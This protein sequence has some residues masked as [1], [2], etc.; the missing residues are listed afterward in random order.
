MHKRL[1]LKYRL[2]IIVIVSVTAISVLFPYFCTIFNFKKSA[3]R[4][5]RPQSYGKYVVIS[6]NGENTKIDIEEFIP[7]VL[8]SIMPQDYSDEQLKA[9]AVIIRTY[10]VYRLNEKNKE[11]GQQDGTVDSIKNENLGLPFTTYGELEKKWGKK[12]EV[13]YNH[14]MKLL[15]ETNREVIYFEGEPIFP[16]YHELSAGMTNNGEFAYL[17]SVESKWDMESEDYMRVMYFTVDNVAEKLTAIMDGDI[18]LESL[19]EGICPEYVENSEYVAKVKV[20]EKE[21][22]IDEWQQ[23]FE[24]PSQAFTVEPFADGFKFV[25]K[26]VGNGKGMSLYGAGKMAEEGKNYKEILSYY[27]TGVDI[28][29]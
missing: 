7:L 4:I 5:Y 24:L 28:H 16:Y 19:A 27:Y 12:Y 26:G 1:L 15:E 25:S 21:I 14:T 3:I 9:M 13:K 6:N 10:I 20:G 11:S 2:N 17:K 22:G 29:D 23:L 18:P 8:Y